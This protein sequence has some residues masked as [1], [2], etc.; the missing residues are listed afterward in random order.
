[1][2]LFCFLIFYILFIKNLSAHNYYSS[3]Y[4]QND[5]DSNNFIDNYES[6]NRKIFNFN[7]KIDKKLI[8]NAKLL[9]KSKSTPTWI[10]RSLN[11]IVNNLSEP[12]H[13]VNNILQFDV[14]GFKNSFWRFALNTTLGFGGLVDIAES[15]GI[16]YDR[17]N[18]FDKTLAYYGVKNQGYLVL[19]FIGGFTFRSLFG[20]I[21]DFLFNPL[22]YLL[23]VWTLKYQL[24][25]YI[26]FL[27]S[28]SI[29]IGSY[30][31]E[32]SLDIYKSWRQTIV[33]NTDYKFN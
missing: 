8:E 26:S 25:S 11:N 6:F 19:P 31:S 28:E 24:I 14:I 27:K 10:K 33:Q 23:P 1:M 18:G 16:P 17:T 9:Y 4:Y 20:A 29:V 2:K 3:Y 12:F 15:I 22:T 13:I 30:V 21:A 7:Y 5:N 32:M